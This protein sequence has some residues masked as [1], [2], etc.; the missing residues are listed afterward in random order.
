M[1]SYLDAT[2]P[3]R[4]EHLWRYTPWSRIYP[5]NIDTIPEVQSALGKSEDLKL[6]SSS[7]EPFSSTDIARIFLNEILEETVVFHA[8]MRM[9]TSTSMREGMLLL[10]TF[11]FLAQLHPT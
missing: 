10:H 1:T 2:V 11:T 8:T 5:G 9:G 6:D 7:F 3:S 4:S